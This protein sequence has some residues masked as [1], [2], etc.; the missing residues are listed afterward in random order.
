MSKKLEGQT[1]SVERSKISP[2]QSSGPLHVLPA[3]GMAHSFFTVSEDG[4]ILRTSDFF[5][6]GDIEAVAPDLKIVYVPHDDSFGDDENDLATE[7]SELQAA[8]TRFE[9]APL[10]EDFDFTDILEP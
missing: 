7:M 1:L 6:T 5:S 8:L 3:S 4:G 9:G 10:P 2:A